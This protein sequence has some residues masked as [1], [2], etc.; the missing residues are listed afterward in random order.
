MTIADERSREALSKVPEITI[1]FWIVKVL[2][3][4]VGETFAD[5]V[6]ET[7]G[8]GLT[9]TTI[10]M[11]GLLGAVLWWQFATRGYIPFVYWMVVVLV[12]IVG[13]LATDNLT[14]RFGVDL[15]IST[16]V[17]AVLLGLVFVWWHRSE[18][19]LSIHSIR[20]TRPEVF[21]WLTILLTFA[22]GTAAGD[23]VSEQFDLG[24]GRAILLFAGAIMLVVVAHFV[25][26]VN[27]VLTFWIAYVL[28]RPLG[29][30]IGDYLSQ[31]RD[32]GGI[33]W[34]TTI[35][36]VTFLA[37]IFLVVVYLTFGKQKSVSRSD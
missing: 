32:D 8:F 18:G 15:K 16:T 23:L 20:S 28:T 21:Y 17:F 22:L 19:T 10:L 1:W 2:C 30:S 26:K 29:G 11:A 36:S 37:V 24:F 7:L 27:G 25:V 33:G 13:T 4:T 14:D 6:N 3:T 35:T 31:S 12:S 5:Y 34:G 9:N